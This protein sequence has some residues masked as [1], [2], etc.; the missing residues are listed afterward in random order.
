MVNTQEIKF[1][2]WYLLTAI[3]IVAISGLFFGLTYYG[4]DQINSALEGTNCIIENNYFVSNCQELWAMSIYPFLA[5]KD[6]LIWLSYFFIFG[7]VLSIFILGYNSGK[8]PSTIG[9]F[10]LLVIGLTYGAIEISNMYRSLLDIPIIYTILTPFPVYNFIMW[11]FPT[12]VFIV[13]LV[14]F[15]L[16][17]INFQKS[18]INKPTD[19]SF[20]F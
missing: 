10:L 8:S 17:I 3:G 15:I 6:I 1:G 4:M 12:F 7:S 16:S 9:I 20:D 13:S 5:L 19:E 18:P 11:N 2:A 14:G